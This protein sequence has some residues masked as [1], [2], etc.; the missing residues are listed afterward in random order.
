MIQFFNPVRCMNLLKSVPSNY[1]KWEN[2]KKRTKNLNN[3]I[4]IQNDFALQI[5]EGVNKTSGLKLALNLISHKF[6]N[7]KKWRYHKIVNKSKMIYFIEFL[8]F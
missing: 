6:E 8:I 7:I 1:F 2:T 3:M 5:M 4:K